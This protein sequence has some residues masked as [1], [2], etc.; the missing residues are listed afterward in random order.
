MKSDESPSD[1]SLTFGIEN[2][3]ARLAAFACFAIRSSSRSKLEKKS[4]EVSRTEI[5]KNYLE[6]FFTFFNHSKNLIFGIFGS[7]KK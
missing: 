6:S 7:T 1:A 3:G 2:R 4:Y 5:P